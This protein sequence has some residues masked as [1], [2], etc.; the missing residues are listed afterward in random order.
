MHGLPV[1]SIGK[2]G[3]SSKNDV[4]VASDKNSGSDN[5]IPGQGAVDHQVQAIGQRGIVRTVHCSRG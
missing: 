3:G 5:A 4:S 1:F 2:A